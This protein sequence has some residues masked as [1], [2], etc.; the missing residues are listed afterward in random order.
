MANHATE[1]APA[2]E[3]EDLVDLPEAE[4]QK[5]P[6]RHAQIKQTVGNQ[7]FEGAVEDIECGK[8][9]GQRLYRVRYADGDLQHFTAEEIREILVEDFDGEGKLMK[10][11]AGSAKRKADEDVEG[12]IA[13]KPAMAM[14]ADAEEEAAEEEEDAA[15]E[16]EEEEEE[17][18]E[19]EEEE[20]EEAEEEEE[21]A[22]MKKP[23]SA[24][25]VMKKPAAAGEADEEE[26]EEEEEEAE[27]EAEE[28]AVMKR[29]SGV[30]AGRA[31]EKEDEAEEE[32]A[33]D[34][35]VM[36]KPAG[37]AKGKEPSRGARG[38]GDEKTGSCGFSVPSEGQVSLSSQG[39]PGQEQGQGKGERQGE[40][41]ELGFSISRGPD[42]RF[43]IG[44]GAG[45]AIGVSLIGEGLL[46]ASFADSSEG[47]HVLLK[48]LE[49]MHVMD[50]KKLS[51]MATRA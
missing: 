16:E 29:P 13:K 36:K 28:Q 31:A 23:A 45:G 48:S 37:A 17:E 18:D 24:G 10:K 40:V 8:I 42:A 19:E 20:E 46:T 25:A 12:S 34:D 21:E 49:R 22:V 9:T 11:P 7:I 41:T 35:A 15:E 14:E 39:F 30:S 38:S 51:R 27:E 50:G 1:S 3:D 44:S 33:A 26:A 47:M 6:L 2:E 32:A 4:K 5:D 43:L